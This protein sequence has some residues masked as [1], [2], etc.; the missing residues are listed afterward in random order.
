MLGSSKEF[1]INFEN[2][3]VKA[4]SKDSSQF[5]KQLGSKLGEE[6]RN[7]IKPFFLRR[8]KKNTVMKKNNLTLQIQ[9]VQKEAVRHQKL[10]VKHEIVLWLP[11]N[12]FHLHVY[13]QY[14]N[15]DIINAILNKKVSPLQ[16]L[17]LLKDL[18]THPYSVLSMEQ[19][20]KERAKY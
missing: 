20:E 5:E 17:N 12:S 10:P 6:L 11:L 9:G 14:L 4:S 15:K 8:E 3:I 18:S 19:F 7:M 16:L 2:K 13:N 1:R